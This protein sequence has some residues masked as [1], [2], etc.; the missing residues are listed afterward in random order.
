MWLG[1]RVVRD[2]ATR[3][4]RAGLSKN[5]VSFPGRAV[6]GAWRRYLVEV[7]SACWRVSAP[8]PWTGWCAAMWTSHDLVRA[9]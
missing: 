2:L 5:S 3:P 4:V 6:T 8:R 9:T 1:L 7:G